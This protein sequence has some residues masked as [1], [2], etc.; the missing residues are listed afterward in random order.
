[1]APHSSTLAWKI[2]WTEEPGRLLGSNNTME[3]GDVRVR[4]R[5]AGNA[6]LDAVIREG[7]LVKTLRKHGVSHVSGNGLCKGPEAGV[8]LAGVG[9]MENAV[10]LR[11]GAQKERR[12]EV[13]Q[14]R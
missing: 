12:R 7:Y 11:S 14:E 6:A 5:M 9:R 2:P 1:M 3:K 13:R 8:C 4:E 10:W